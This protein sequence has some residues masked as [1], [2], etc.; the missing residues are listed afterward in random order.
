MAEGNFNEIH[1][2]VGNESTRGLRAQAEFYPTLED[3][4]LESEIL[5]HYRSKHRRIA[6]R[7]KS[8]IWSRH[9]AA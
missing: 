1:N 4:A 9:R 2:S 5:H 3:K 6:S 7:M 8:S